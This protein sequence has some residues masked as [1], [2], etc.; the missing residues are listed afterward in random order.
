MAEV[1]GS[2]WLREAL[3]G[4]GL[5][6]EVGALLLQ[7][8]AKYGSANIDKHGLKGILVRIDDKLARLNHMAGEFPDESVEDAW[9]DVA[10]Y[11]LIALMKLRGQWGETTSS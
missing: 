2:E 11:A 8:N 9:M 5:L 6:D 4:S 3:W 10:G 1:E 7:R